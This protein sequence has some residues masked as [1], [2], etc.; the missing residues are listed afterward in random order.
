MATA[1][2][3]DIWLKIAEYGGIVSF[4]NLMLLNRSFYQNFN[5]RRLIYLKNNR[6]P[7]KIVAQNLLRDFKKRENEKFFSEMMEKNILD[8]ILETDIEVKNE[9]YLCALRCDRVDF[10]ELLKNKFAFDVENGDVYR[11]IRGLLKCCLGMDFYDKSVFGTGI[12][13]CY[14]G[15]F[16]EVICHQSENVFMYL[17]KR[18]NYLISKMSMHYVDNNYFGKIRCILIPIIY[19]NNHRLFQHLLENITIHQGFIQIFECIIFANGFLYE[20]K[21]TNNVAELTGIFIAYCVEHKVPIRYYSNLIHIP[22]YNLLCAELIRGLNSEELCRVFENTLR[23]SQQTNIELMSDIHHILMSN[24]NQEDKRHRLNFMLSQLNNI[25]CVANI[26]RITLNLWKFMLEKF[27][28]NR[29]IV[30]RRLEFV[31]KYVEN[32]E[33]F[34]LLLSDLR[35]KLH[36]RTFIYIHKLKRLRRLKTVKRIAEIFRLIEMLLDDGRTELNLYHWA[37]ELVLMISGLEL[38]AKH[39]EQHQIN[40]DRFIPIITPYI[41]N[42]IQR[43]L[44]FCHYEQRAIKRWIQ[45]LRSFLDAN[46]FA[47][48]CEANPVFEKYLIEFDRL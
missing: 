15:H 35:L 17:V 38:L 32:P 6:Q 39:P 33:I 29:L 24:K 36:S 26:K 40:I 9:M 44:R 1:I 4:R 23:R 27:D 47:Q 46:A 28:V 45:F 10:I 5:Q 30:G 8:A 41:T 42:Y 31:L 43:D 21:Y 14:E 48:Y 18:I 11:Q 16:D 20:K 2:G 7:A 3:Y 25:I 12:S 19:Y 13:C 22:K 34:Q 37:S